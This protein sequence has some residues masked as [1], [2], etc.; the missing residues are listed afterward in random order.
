[1]P[2]HRC[3]ESLQMRSE[4][5]GRR[6]SGDSSGSAVQCGDWEPFE[7]MPNPSSTGLERRFFLSSLHFHEIIRKNTPKTLTWRSLT[8]V[9]LSAG[10]VLD[11]I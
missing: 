2:L 4:E 1:M 6:H 11:S 3:H 9:L 10:L 8:F 5:R 7:L